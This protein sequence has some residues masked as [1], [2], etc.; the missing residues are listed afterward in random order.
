MLSFD[1]D[2][3]SGPELYILSNSELEAHVLK[4][5]MSENLPKSFVLGL[6]DIEH[7]SVGLLEYQ[8]VLLEATQTLSLS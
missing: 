6:G 8:T 1:L 2:S 7:H 3:Y 4:G 5:S